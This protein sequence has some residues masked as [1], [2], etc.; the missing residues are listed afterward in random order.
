MLRDRNALYRELDDGRIENVYSVRIINKDQ[1]RRTNSACRRSDLPERRRRQRCA[2]AVRRR[3]GGADRGRARARARRPEHGG[4]DFRIRVQAATSRGIAVITRTRFFAEPETSEGIDHEC[5][6]PNLPWYR[7]PMMWLVVAP[8]IAA[9]LGRAMTWADPAQPRRPTCARRM[10]S[11]PWPARH[12]DE[13]RRSAGGLS[14][15]DRHPAGCFHC[16]EPLDGGG[17]RARVCGAEVAVCCPGC[18]AAA[19]L[20]GELGLEDFYRYRTATAERPRQ[21]RRMARLRRAGG[22]GS[23]TRREADGRSVVLLI[24]GLHLR[25]V[26]LADQPVL[27]RIDG[28]VRTSVNTATAAPTVVWDPGRVRIVAAA[29]RH[30]RSRLPAAPRDRRTRAA[31]RAGTNGAPC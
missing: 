24:D 13:F 27:E 2:V 20:I 14:R 23:L 29:A 5:A 11:W 21:S 1:Q 15:R 22:A 17:S 7:Y 25:G 3:R 19:Q 10:P 28:V 12:R 31:I 18:R 26:Q 30:R 9:V 8:P 6:D 16:G 4:R